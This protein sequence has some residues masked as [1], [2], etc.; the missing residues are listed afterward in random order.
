MSTKPPERYQ[1]I[2]EQFPDVIDAYEK[3]GKA[4]HQGP[5]EH[6][7]V[8]LIK[9]AASAAIK[10]EGAVHS[11]TRK[12]LEV[13]ATQDEIRHAIVLLTNTVGFANMMAALSW[14]DDVLE[15]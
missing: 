7:N 12:A 2:K 3:L 9:L 13:G 14:V 5:I 1:M 10:S 11:H 4:T 6:K 15:K 8:H